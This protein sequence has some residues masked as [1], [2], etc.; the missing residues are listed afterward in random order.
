MSFTVKP[1]ND[2][3]AIPDSTARSCEE[4]CPPVTNTGEET[5]GESFITKFLLAIIAKYC[6]PIKKRALLCKAL[7]RCL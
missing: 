2:N 7:L 3:S 1:G 4:I 6:L 5:D